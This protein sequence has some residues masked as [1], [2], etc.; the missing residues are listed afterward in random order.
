MQLNHIAGNSYY[1]DGEDAVGVY[2]FPDHSCLLIDSGP[3]ESHAKKIMKVL[4]EQGINVRAILNTHAHVD[5]CGGNSYI[6]AQTK[7]KIMASAASAAV[8][9]NPLLGPAMLFSAYPLRV[10]RSR[11]LMPH[12]SKVDDIIQPGLN[13][14]N[15]WEFQTL[16]L[17]GH[18]LGQI[19]LVTPDGVAFL[20]DSLMH[21]DMLASYPFLYMVDITSQLATLDFILQKNWPQVFLTHGGLVDDLALCVKN[22]QARINDIIDEIMALL[23]TSRSREEILAAMIKKYELRVNS[24]QYYLVSSTISAFLSHLCQQKKLY[25]KVE[26]GV[27]KFSRISKS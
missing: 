13:K 17:P 16:D 26:E 9:E 2:I 11:A 21:G 7:C 20:G 18:S 14:I 6:K 3:S 23:E 25:N 24:V 4:D 8:I 1:L 10:L 12:P 19:G 5:H 22:N 15:N 27:M